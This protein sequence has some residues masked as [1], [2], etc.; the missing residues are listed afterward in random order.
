MLTS[1]VV[2]NFRLFDLLRIERLGRLNLVVGRNNS[3]KSA[4]LEAVELYVSNAST[5]VL[6]DLVTNRQETWR[7]QP[8]IEDEIIGVNPIRHLFH[9]HDLPKFGQAGILVGPIGTEADQIHIVIAAYRIERSEEG[10]PHRVLV[11]GSELP[12][13]LSDI[14][15]SLVARENGKVRR[16]L[17]LDR[18]LDQEASIY[19]RNATLLGAASRYPV[20]VVPTRNMTDEKL[21]TL[22]DQTTLT[23]LDDEVIK[24]LQLL[25]TNI[26]GVAFVEG[27]DRRNRNNRIPIIK[28]SRAT[29]P[30]PLKTMGDGMT[31]LFHIVV[32]LVNAKNGILLVDEFENG[33]HWSVQPNIWK[34][35]FRLAQRLNVQVFASTHSRDCI[36]G[37]EEAWKEQEEMGAFFRLEVKLDVG[38]AVTSY[39]CE[40][41]S[42]SLETGVEPR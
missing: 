17:R 16:I 31:R 9:N 42:D 36:V 29:E 21:A 23:G 32:A 12:Q 28:T 1:F 25:D 38:V 4:L 2:K 26:T 7:G 20:E 19:R 37:F 24:G 14:E 13:D 11:E 10:V 15:L 39:S 30:L 40:T 5:Q 6:I 27:T 41:L 18:E 3:G 22:W 34:I 33:L 8:Q 35:V